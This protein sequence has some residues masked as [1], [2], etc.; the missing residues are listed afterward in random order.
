[1]CTSALLRAQFPTCTWDGFACKKS[2]ARKIII[3]EGLWFLD[4]HYQF[5]DIH[6]YHYSLQSGLL[7][8]IY[9]SLCLQDGRLKLLQEFPEF[10]CCSSWFIGPVYFL[11]YLVQWFFLLDS[12]LRIL[13][14]NFKLLSHS[15]PSFLL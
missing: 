11:K 4:C 3:Y 13:I 10:H 14:P 8:Y 5:G 2:C 6:Q 1:M 9:L 12:Q 7:L 15:T